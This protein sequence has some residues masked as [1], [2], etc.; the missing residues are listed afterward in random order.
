ML[1]FLLKLQ[2]VE[3]EVLP[4][5]KEFTCFGRSAVF[6]VDQMVF[7]FHIY[8]CDHCEKVF[9]SCDDVEGDL[10]FHGILCDLI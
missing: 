1:S 6:E 8:V 9:V 2:D 3:G 4:L 10:L 5:R 7:I